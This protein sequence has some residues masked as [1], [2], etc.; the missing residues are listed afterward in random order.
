MTLPHGRLGASPQVI[1]SGS[2]DTLREVLETARERGFLGPGPVEPHIR[3]SLD[4]LEALPGDARGPAGRLPQALELNALDLG[5]GGGVPGL[6]LALALPLSRWV[7]LEASEKRSA[8]LA[9]AVRRLGLKRRVS[10]AT[11]RAE[12][13]GRGPMRGSFD[14]VVARSFAAPAVTAECAAPLL[15]VGGLLI[16]AEPPAG[17]A[18]AERSPVD[19]SS[20]GGGPVASSP[21]GGGPVASSPVGGGPVGGGPDASSPVGGS[22]DASSPVGGGPDASS[23]VGGGPVAG[24]S[25]QGVP[26]QGA[27]ARPAGPTQGEGRWPPETLA[28]LGLVPVAHFDAPSALQL[29]E[30]QAPCPARYPR[31]TGIPSKRPLF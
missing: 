26:V 1:A 10:V 24:G 2:L 11:V 28:S 8:F 29:L 27:P 20:V 12:E 4:F 6:V 17:V 3:R 30:Q 14:L 7:L 15:R 22:P 31:R 16:V 19:S 25:A 5:S 13:A 23:P 21:V 18:G 9:E